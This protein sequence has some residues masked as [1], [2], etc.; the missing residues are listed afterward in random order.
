M[1]VGLLLTIMLPAMVEYRLPSRSLHELT[2]PTEN[3]SLSQLSLPR[4][5]PGRQQEYPSTTANGGMYQKRQI[6][7]ETDNN[8]KRK[9]SGSSGHPNSG[10]PRSCDHSPSKGAEP[11]LVAIR[12]LRAT[13]NADQNGSGHHTN[14]YSVDQNGHNGS[15][16]A[17]SD[18]QSTEALKC[19]THTEDVDPRPRNSQSTPN[20]DLS[21]NQYDRD[22]PNTITVG[23]PTRKRKFN[24]RTKTGCLTCR[25]RKKKCDETHPICEQPFIRIFS[26]DSCDILIH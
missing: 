12:A 21:R 2:I 9:R 8:H 6:R 17:T 23:T 10:N 1:L 16:C 24:N 22:S 26:C 15:R 14:R 25:R 4:D 11:H 18:V 7:E 20:D 19:E 3:G 13:G 5:G